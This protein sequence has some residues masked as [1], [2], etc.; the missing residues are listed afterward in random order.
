KDRLLA[1][2]HHGTDVVQIQTGTALFLERIDVDSI[3]HRLYR[4]AHRLGGVLEQIASSDLQFSFIHP[5]DTSVD[6]L[7]HMR[8]V[9]RWHQ[10]VAPADVDLVFQANGNRHRRESMVELSVV[11]DDGTHAA[12]P[13]AWQYLDGV[14]RLDHARSY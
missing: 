5:Y 13:P 1:V 9:R 6:A 14:A 7:R 3:P 10:H 12:S 11:T 4:G 2:D 8:R